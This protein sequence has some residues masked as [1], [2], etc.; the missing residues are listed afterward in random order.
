[1][2]TQAFILESTPQVYGNTLLCL[3]TKTSGKLFSITGKPFKSPS[4]PARIE[5][6]LL[7]KKEGL[8]TTQALY[9]EDTFPDLRLHEKAQKSLFSLHQLM[10][11][12]LPLHTALEEVWTLFSSLMPCLHLF[13]EESTPLFLMAYTLAA[14][15]GI[16]LSW[17]RESAHLDEQS[18]ESI[19]SFPM[20]S[21]EEIF[22]MRYPEQALRLILEELK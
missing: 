2:L 3:L 10:K 6:E 18:K 19:L 15:Q 14:S 4:M 13:Q 16:D 8:Y 11:Q 17:I 22:S 12:T 21:G 5:I 20:L 1:M 7:Q 9:V